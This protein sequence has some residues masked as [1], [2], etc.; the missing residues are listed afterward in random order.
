MLPRPLVPLLVLV[1]A[2]QP[3][4]KPS[5]DDH[6]V[7]QI[8]GATGW[9]KIATADH[10]R[11]ET[12]FVISSFPTKPVIA[13][14]DSGFFQLHDEWFYFRLLNGQVVPGL[15]GLKPFPGHQFATIR[16]VFDWAKTQTTL[17]LELQWIDGSR[18]YSPL[19]YDLSLTRRPRSFGLGTLMHVT[20][21]G[22]RPEIW[23]FQLE[24]GDTLEHAE[25]VTFF[26]EL[27]RTLPKDIGANLFWVVRSPAQEAFAQTVIA[28][29]L[30]F[31][32]RILH[33]KDLTVP[34]E[35]EVYS[36]GLT[37]GRLLRLPSGSSLESA[38]AA[39]LLMLEDVPDYLPPASGVITAIPQ[40]PLAHFNLLARNRGIPNVYRAGAFED[41][42]LDTLAYYRAPVV[43][44]AQVPDKLIVKQITEQQL[45]N[46]QTLLAKPP[47]AVKQID[48]GMLPYTYD[49]NA[50]PLAEVDTLRPAFGGKAA[51]YLGLLA[52]APEATPDAVMAVSIRAYAEHVAALKPTFDVMLA[53]SMFTEDSRARFLV[54]EGPADY[55]TTFVSP[56]DATYKASF[57]TAHPQ[58]T[59]LGDFARGEGVKGAIRKLPVASATMGNITAAV[60]AKFSHYGKTQGL[61]FRSSS[62]A[63]DVEGFNGAGLYDSNTG[64]LDPMSAPNPDDRKHGIEWA[65]KKTWAS[66]WAFEAFEERRLENVD[67]LS[68]NMGV[69]VHANFPDAAEKSNGV[70]LFTLGR[71]FSSMELNVQAGALSVTNPTT[72]ALPE[73]SRVTLD[74][75][76]PTTPRIERLRTSTVVV[77]A[78]SQLLTDAQLIETFT[79]ARAVATKWLAQVNSGSSQAQQSRTLV[80][81][82][83]FR[84]V[85]AGWPV[86]TTGAPNPER[87]VLKQSRSLEHGVRTASAAAR[88]LPLPKDVFARARRIERRTCQSDA[89]TAIIVEANT[90]PLLA[91]DLGFSTTPF[92]GSVALT[93]KKEVPALERAMGS[94]VTFEH[95]SLATVTH[96]G[97][98]NGT[99]GLSAL[100]TAARAAS[101]KLSEVSLRADGTFKLVGPAAFEGSGLTCTVEVM[102][103]TPNEYLMSLLPK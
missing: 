31:H 24:F 28:Q 99:W 41:D 58:G 20:A 79:R 80:L 10:G 42:E 65:L 4:Q 19:F 61:R 27:Q 3:P 73:I 25:L 60:T 44:S 103:S 49:L 40:T 1:C 46:W 15:D 68:G 36:P 57:L 96:P 75:A 38:K 71:D 50:T 6:T 23:A 13:Y 53:D 69:V 34:G 54:L 33:P 16:E 98:G 86:L 67:H 85:F 30:R 14:Y 62:T 89:F 95:P 74:A 87:I 78:G 63:E 39:S 83:E 56:A 45:L 26:E 92:T 101:D 90:D 11:E 93:F 5:F 102:F 72:T 32:D 70:F 17:P 2:C 18:L 84:Q 7:P 43:M 48:V 47:V 52:G 100:P 59:A 12:K 8:G 88:A 81:D 97:L 66:Y 76:S 55:D 51:G 77:P 29:K 82:F 35:I 91:P 37:A 9:A 64:Y 22:P 94:T 21:K